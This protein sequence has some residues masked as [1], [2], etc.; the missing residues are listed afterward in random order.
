V[1]EA[2]AKRQ[3]DAEAA[4]E[5]EA[6]RK[7]M[8]KLETTTDLEFLRA[9]VLKVRREPAAAVQRA[10]R[11]AGA[12]GCSLWQFCLRCIIPSSAGL[13]GARGAARRGAKASAGDRNTTT[14][15]LPAPALL[16]F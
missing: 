10:R 14:T 3:R 12:V 16:A 6:E 5:A 8:H 2:T 4:A 13:C 7:R 11:A 15:R 1:A 9:E